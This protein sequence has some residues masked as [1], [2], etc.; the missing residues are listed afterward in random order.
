MS[1][2]QHASN[3]KIAPRSVATRRTWYC[4]PDRLSGCVCRAKAPTRPE[5]RQLL[6]ALFQFDELQQI[7]GSVRARLKVDALVRE[8]SWPT[9]VL[10]A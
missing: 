4:C 7:A 8:L 5:R 10:S 9:D 1:E 6:E 3:E 2:H